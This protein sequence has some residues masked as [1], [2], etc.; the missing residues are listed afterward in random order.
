M[1]GRAPTGSYVQEH[2]PAPGLPPDDLASLL[3]ANP[4]AKQGIGSSPEW[5]VAQAR[6]AI[7]RGGSALS[8]FRNLNRNERVASDDRSVLVTVDE[9]LASEV[10]PDALP[11]RDGPVILG[12]D[13]GGSRSMSAAALYWPVSGRLEAVGAFRQHRRLRIVGPLMA[14]Q[15]VT[16]KWPSATS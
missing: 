12:V 4:G 16:R 3:V 14:C 9:W 10:S 7:A 11:E 8:S 13:L 15:G 5:L 2:R 6:R 1:V